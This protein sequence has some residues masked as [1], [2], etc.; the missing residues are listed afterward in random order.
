MSRADVSRADGQAFGGAHTASRTLRARWRTASLASGWRFPSDWA[1]PEVD[2]VCVAVITGGMTDTALAGL[3]K[4][5]AAAGTGLAETLTD[6]VAL[7]AVLADPYAV[8]SFI[9]PDIDATPTRLVWATAL[10]WA[11]VAVDRLTSTEVTDP[12]TGLPTAAY[13]RT[14]LGEVY[15]VASRA[16]RPVTED[17]LLLTVSLDLS[18]VVGW[19]RLTA[20]I[21]LADVLRAAFDGGES[22]AI[23]GPSVIAVLLERAGGVSGRA[24]S[25]RRSLNERLM[26]DPQLHSIGRPQFRAVRLRPTHGETCVLLSELARG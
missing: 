17:N 16:G 2:A 6:L 22:I 24:V 21:L 7:Q 10:G 23:L 18:A 3:G 26:V 15:R 11:D 12:L 13:L 1:L 25:V 8:H 5:R 20:M 4:A 9:V 14:R 19:P